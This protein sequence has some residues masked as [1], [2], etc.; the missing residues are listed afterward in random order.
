MTNNREF[1]AR[2]VTVAH[3]IG[4]ALEKIPPNSNHKVYIIGGADVFN[5]FLPWCLYVYVTRFDI[6]TKSDRY[7]PNLDRLP[8]WELM[9]PGDVMES[10]GVFYSFDL[11]RS[12]ALG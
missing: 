2:G 7:F 1:K 4:Q 10:S 12:V 11:Y 8:D 5:Q 3:S 6:I 9:H